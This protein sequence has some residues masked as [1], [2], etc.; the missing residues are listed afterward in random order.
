MKKIHVG[1][2][3]RNV[4]FLCEMNEA[5]LITTFSQLTVFGK[6]I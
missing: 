4:V 6:C 2:T 5:L 1:L 3:R